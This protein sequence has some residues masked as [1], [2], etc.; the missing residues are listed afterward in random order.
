MSRGSSVTT[1]ILLTVWGLAS[2]LSAQDMRTWTDREGHSIEAALVGRQGEQVILERDGRQRRFRMDQLSPEDRR[3]VEKRE[4]EIRSA[5]RTER[6]KEFRFTMDPEDKARLDER[7]ARKL[8][9]LYPKSRDEIQDTLKRIQ[10]AA[11]GGDF[12]AT[13][14]E[15]LSSL[16]AYRYLCDL[17]WDVGLDATYARKAQA[18]AEICRALG[19]LDHGPPNPGMPEEAYK[20]AKEG[21]GHS[22]LFVG[23]GGPPSSVRSFMN[24]SDPSNIDRLGHRRWCLHPRMALT[25]FGHA[26]SYAAMWS[27]DAGRPRDEVPDFEYVAYPPRGFLPVEY[28]RDRYA[29][30]VSLNPAKYKSP[31]ELK[32]DQIR[33]YPLTGTGTTL[34]D[35]SRGDLLEMDYFNVDTGGFG[36]PNCII[37]RPAKIN[38]RRGA[39]YWVE[40]VGLETKGGKPAEIGYLVE[41][42]TL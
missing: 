22:N 3:Y 10:K 20:V 11:A 39:R 17:P 29:W 26:G 21:A 36:L 2:S 38:L 28:F 32:Q 9:G 31:A 33:I 23:G 34:D 30:S 41:F 5:R 15:A 42:T 14:R 16:N 4:R 40:I 35:F 25:G 18:G 37:F 24:D 12:P 6:L 13:H 7:M 27:M 8:D 19:R 1:A